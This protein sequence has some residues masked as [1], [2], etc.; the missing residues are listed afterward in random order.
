M[1]EPSLIKLVNIRASLF[2]Y[3]PSALEKLLESTG[4]HAVMTV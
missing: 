1:L 3:L 4:G 2:L